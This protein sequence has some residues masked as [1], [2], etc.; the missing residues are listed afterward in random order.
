MIKIL[1]TF[2]FVL[3]IRC[4]PFHNEHQVNMYGLISKWRLTEKLSGIVIR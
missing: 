1:L 2:C 4:V 3:L